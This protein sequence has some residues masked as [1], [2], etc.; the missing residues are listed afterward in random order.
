MEFEIGD[1]IYISNNVSGNNED[2]CEVLLSSDYEDG[3][4]TLFLTREQVE[5]TIQALK[6]ILSQ[7]SDYKLSQEDNIH[8][9]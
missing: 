9:N 3:Y 1:D 6:N 4:F 8:G 2:I 5:K 7:A